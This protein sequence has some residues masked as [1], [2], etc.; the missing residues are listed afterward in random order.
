MTTTVFIKPTAPEFMPVRQHESD[1][2]FDV[3][4]AETVTV[5][6]GKVARIP[7]G[8]AMQLSTGWEAQ[9]RGR[10][11]MNTKGL[12]SLFGTVDSGYRG[13]VAAVVYN[14]SDAPWTAEKGMRVAQMAVRP[15][16]EVR[17]VVVDKLAESD[18]GERGFG[19]TGVR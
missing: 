2:C 12:L 16:P 6:A 5:E 3:V 9:I 11:G 18:R 4:A 7:L 15:V 1:A 17:L 19:S 10:S 8:F 14:A 13:E